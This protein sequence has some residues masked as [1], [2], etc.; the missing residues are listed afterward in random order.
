[1]KKKSALVAISD[2]TKLEI[3]FTF[4]RVLEHYTPVKIMFNKLSYQIAFDNIVHLNQFLGCIDSINFNRTLNY[5]PYELVR[6]LVK[7]DE[8]YI[9]ISVIFPDHTSLL[10]TINALYDEAKNRKSFSNNL[11]Y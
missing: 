8:P 11:I 4:T 5:I 10:D 6:D 1:M 2:E 9:T 3:E 7:M